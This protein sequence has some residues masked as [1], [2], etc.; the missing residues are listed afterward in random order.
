MFV[1][2][3]D[4]IYPFSETKCCVWC[5]SASVQLT[6]V[7]LSVKIIVSHEP[8][9]DHMVHGPFHYLHVKCTGELGLC[10]IMVMHVFCICIACFIMCMLVVFVR[11]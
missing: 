4:D 2:T 1:Y 7:N 5:L 8:S 6:A 3:Q 10:A 11:A 9:R